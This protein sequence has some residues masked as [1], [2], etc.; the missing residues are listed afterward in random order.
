MSL[1]NTVLIFTYNS[2]FFYVSLNF[3]IIS[4]KILIALFLVNKKEAFLKK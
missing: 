3:F 2:D 1:K 4:F